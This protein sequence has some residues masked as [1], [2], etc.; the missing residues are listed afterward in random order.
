MDQQEIALDNI[1]HFIQASALANAILLRQIRD[2][3]KEEPTD[4]E[5]EE[6]AKF[7]RRVS[8]ILEPAGF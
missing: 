8:A 4:I 2:G 7:L 3:K 5:I 1:K 6:S